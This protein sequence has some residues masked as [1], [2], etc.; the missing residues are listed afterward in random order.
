MANDAITGQ[1]IFKGAT[2]V[3]LRSV[4]S[5][6]VSGH[7]FVTG[8]TIGDQ[9]EMRVEF[10]FVTKKITVIASG[11]QGLGGLRVHFVST[12]STAQTP[13]AL[14]PTQRTGVVPGKHYI[15]L[16]SH[17]DSV[18]LDVKCKELY[19]SSPNGAGGFMLYA[20]LTNI[21]TGSM[22]AVTGSGISAA[23]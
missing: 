1:P 18:D 19:L 20:S 5:Y 9:I 4:G 2:G 22:Y 6:Q 10:P 12:G 3:G 14:F 16:N 7:P 23:Y 17:E 11:S 15:H 21:S 8:S 13:N